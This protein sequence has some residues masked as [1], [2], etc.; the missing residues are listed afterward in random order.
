M[1]SFLG[2]SRH[3]ITV[4]LYSVHVRK[5]QPFTTWVPIFFNFFFR[6]ILNIAD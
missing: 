3:Q 1:F 6:P 5:M 2:V 4:L